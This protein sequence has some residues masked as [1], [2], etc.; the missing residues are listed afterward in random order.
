MTRWLSSSCDTSKAQAL[1]DECWSARNIPARG[2]RVAVVTD[3]LEQ[4]V[5]LEDVR[6]LAGHSDLKTTQIYD[7]PR[8]RVIRN[9]V[10]RI[11]TMHTEKPVDAKRTMIEQSPGKS[12]ISA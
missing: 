7:L 6:Y 9:I 8:R 4:N 10:E 11:S 3:L 2:F 12:C 5:P 1:L